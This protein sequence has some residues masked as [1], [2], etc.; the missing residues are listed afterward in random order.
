MDE[1]V[2]VSGISSQASC[3][4][5]AVSKFP[6]PSHVFNSLMEHQRLEVLF[7]P[8]ADIA[9][10]NVVGFQGTVR[11]PSNDFLYSPHR[12]LHL[13]HQSGKPLEFENLRCQIMALRF[14]ELGLSGKL[15]ITLNADIFLSHKFK[16]LHVGK[17]IHQAG[18]DP[19]QVVIELSGENIYSAERPSFLQKIVSRYIDLGY[20]VAISDHGEFFPFLDADIENPPS[21]AKLN[22]YLIHD[23]D[24]MPE[25]AQ[26]VQSLLETAQAANC[27]IIAEGVETRGELLLLRDIGIHL[28]Q[29]IFIARWQKN[30]SSALSK[31]AFG[32]LALHASTEAPDQKDCNP[33]MEAAHCFHMKDINENVFMHLEEN[34][35][36]H[37]AAV[38]DNKNAPV[39][40][41]NR[42]SFI[43]RFARTYQR[44]LYGKKP[45]TL[46]MDPE[47]LIVDRNISIQDLSRLVSMDHRHVSQGF[48]FTEKGQ[49]VGVGTSQSLIHEITEMQIRAARYANPL[50]GL[51]G[52]LPINEHINNLLNALEPFCVCYCDLNH[53]KPFNDVY[54]FSMGDSMIQMTAKILVEICDQHLDFV[55][56]IG[57]DDFIIIFRSAD[58]EDR[59]RSGLEKFGKNALSFFRSE[60]IERGGYVTENRREEEEFH[61]LTSLSMGAVVVEP[62]MFESHREIASVAAESKKMAKKNQGNSLYINQRRYCITQ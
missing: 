58:W 19:E 56:H 43:D 35:M 1:R 5:K 10:G 54:G 17:F 53:F 3:V 7:Q 34:P 22:P 25:K 4:E 6:E 24:K 27:K 29:G 45:C 40:L 32:A 21:Y 37:V 42:A 60:D 38:V 46:F 50:S 62:G 23:I 55:G 26:F 12:L 61:P 51:P 33:L 18:L 59:C 47:P 16:D 28:C 49:Y 57:G 8:V 20:Q 14:A 30:P 2:N 52:N 15:F 9:S 41:I 31:E 13:A 36:L 39:G 48:I 44:E 11:G